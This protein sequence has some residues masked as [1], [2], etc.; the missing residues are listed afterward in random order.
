MSVA[1]ATAIVA[2]GCHSTFP[3]PAGSLP[4]RTTGLPIAVST[5]RTIVNDGSLV[6]FPLFEYS[7]SLVVDIA[8][9]PVY[10]VLAGPTCALPVS[11]G[12]LG[13]AMLAFHRSAMVARMING[14]TYIRGTWPV[15]ATRRVRGTTISRPPEPG[16]PAITEFVSAMYKGG[17]LVHSQGKLDIVFVEPG[18]YQAGTPGNPGVKVALL[19]PDG[20]EQSQVD[21]LP[22]MYYY[23]E[24]STSVPNSVVLKPGVPW[25]LTGGAQHDPLAKAVHDAM[26][27]SGL[28]SGV[29]QM[30]T[31]PML[32]P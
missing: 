31:I 23:I 4:V 12:S 1:S 18:T 5:P 20:S 2:T 32:T 26:R 11:D 29:Q 28:S 21:L 25:D 22:G 10:D 24:D 27:K 8:G 19:R 15:P 3:R 30:T 16:E 13:P 17:I 7:H 14:A 6:T 9:A